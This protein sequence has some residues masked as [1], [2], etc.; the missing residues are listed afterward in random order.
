MEFSSLLMIQGILLNFYGTI[1]LIYEIIIDI[2]GLNRDVI[3]PI[4]NLKKSYIRLE[5]KKEGGYNEVKLTK[6]EKR[7]IWWFLF[8]LLGV[9]L[10]VISYLI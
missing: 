4:Y 1:A 3:T 6:K 9:I 5:A 10:Q 2:K 7:L 8:I